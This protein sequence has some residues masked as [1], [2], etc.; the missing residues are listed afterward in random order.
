MH[1]T[2]CLEHKADPING[3][4]Y[5]NVAFILTELRNGTL[6]SRFSCLLGVIHVYQGQGERRPRCP[7]Q[8]LI[9]WVKSSQAVA[10]LHH[11]KPHTSR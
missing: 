6:F 10:I 7:P 1:F 5:D 8:T 3:G 4:S 11:Q 2:W 9:I